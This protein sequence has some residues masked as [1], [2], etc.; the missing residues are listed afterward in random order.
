MRDFLA[1]A[2]SSILCIEITECIDIDQT[3]CEDIIHSIFKLKDKAEETLYDFGMDY[4]ITIK[5]IQKIRVFLLKWH[6]E[7]F[8]NV[9]FVGH[10]VTSVPIEET[11]LSSKI[12]EFIEDYMGLIKYVDNMFK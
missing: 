12:E 1:I 3:T 4:T 9:K 8:I 7:F 10:T 11:V 2:N 6:S 5:F